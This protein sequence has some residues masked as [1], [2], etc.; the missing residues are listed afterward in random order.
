M[1]KYF[2]IHNIVRIKIQ[3]SSYLK[4]EQA[5]YQ[6]REFEKP[7]LEDKDIELFIYDYSECP[8]LK[9]PTVLSNYYYYSDNYLNVPCEKLCFN[10]IDTPLIV[11]CDDFRIS[12]NFLI[13][14]SL[15]RKGYSFIH[16]AAVEYHGKNYLFPA[17]GGVGKTTTVAS[18][19]FDGGRLFGDDINIVKQKEVLSY[20]MDFSVY[21][22]HLDILKFK[23]RKVEYQFK[24]TKILD[25]ITNKLRRYSFRV[26]KL[27]IL[28]LNSLK[29]PYVNIPAKDIF[30]KDCIKEKGQIDEVYY[31]TRVGG[32]LSEI[33][34]QQIDSDKLAEIGT[35]VLLQ[36]WHGAMNLVYTYSGLSSFSLHSL[37]IKIRDIFRGTFQNYQCYQI[38]IPATLDNLNYQEQLISYFNKR[39][40]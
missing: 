3:S 29:T 31:L 12:L 8:V 25:G 19:L 2:N 17:F 38:K 16:A 39:K 7:L 5:A 24:K 1:A 22:Y 27:L 26:S 18:L 6:L 34:V 10:F 36:E 32:D 35:N 28:I 40:T 33:S 37:F 14:L 11:Y 13:E 21:P 4:Y 20:P 9:N 30:G 15:L 23:D